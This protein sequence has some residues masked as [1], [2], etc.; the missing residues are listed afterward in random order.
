MVV[1]AL[2]TTRFTFGASI[3]ATLG[4]LYRFM[5]LDSIRTIPTTLV[6]NTKELKPRIRNE[7]EVIVINLNPRNK[8]MMTD[9]LRTNAN[10]D[11]RDT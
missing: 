5:N 9:P 10:V 7:P 1:V 6:F 2:Y 4:L 11:D 3:F 8:I